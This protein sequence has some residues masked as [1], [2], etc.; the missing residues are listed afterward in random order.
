MKAG[1]SENALSPAIYFLALACVVEL[2]AHLFNS[3]VGSMP[4][5]AFVVLL[6][7]L[8]TYVGLKLPENIYS[9][10]SASKATGQSPM[11]AVFNFSRSHPGQIYFP[12]FPLTVLM[13]EGRLYDFSWGLSD[14]RA[15]GYP[16][17]EAHFL[18]H[19]P[20]SAHRMALLPW[21][22]PWENDIYSRC[23]DG[24]PVSSE[25]GLP[26]FEICTFR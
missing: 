5:S 4:R 23:T 10:Y 19:T 20:A 17:S 6:L 2:S 21:V 18:E 26:G 13:T 1:G 3:S 25:P 9:V 22:R 16:V 11:E 7:V 12:Q 24:K 15:A 8:G 14:R